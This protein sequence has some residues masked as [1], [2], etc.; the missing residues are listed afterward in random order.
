MLPLILA[1][2]SSCATDALEIYMVPPGFQCCE[3]EF[4][5]RSWHRDWGMCNFTRFLPIGDPIADREN[6]SLIRCIVGSR[7]DKTSCGF[8]ALGRSKP[9]FDVKNLFFSIKNVFCLKLDAK[10]V[11]EALATSIRILLVFSIVLA[12]T[13]GQVPN[14]KAFFFLSTPLEKSGVAGYPRGLMGIHVPKR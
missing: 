3:R 1:A 12:Y 10:S 14:L 4:L 6:I 9:L 7:G 11:P 2:A 13:R 8:D 5:G